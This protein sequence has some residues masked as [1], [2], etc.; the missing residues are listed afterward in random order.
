MRASRP[1]CLAVL[2]V[3]VCLGGAARGDLVFLKDGY[4]L[5]GSVRREM[6]SEFDQISK[7]MTLIPKGFFMVDDGPRRVYFSPTQVRIVEKLPAPAEE[8]VVS[9]KGAYIMSTQPMPPLED[10]LEITPWDYKT[11]RREYMFLGTPNRNV[12]LRQGLAT[13]DP[14]FARVDAVTKYPWSS[15]YLTREWDPETVYKLLLGHPDFQDPPV[16]TLKTVLAAEAKAAADLKARVARSKTPLKLVKP[17]KVLSNEEK[18]QVALDF[19]ER[20]IV[21]QRMRLVDFFAQAGW[22]DLAD[23]ELD[24]LLKDKSSEKERVAAARE[25]VDK[26]RVRDLWEQTKKWYHG[27]Q[28][29]AVRKRIAAFPTKNVSDRIQADL[30][31]MRAR[32]ESSAAL[33][34]EAD[35]ALQ[36][37]S[38]AVSTAEGRAL[39]SAVNVIRG[40]LHPATIDRLDA[41]LGQVRDWERQ[42]ARG[43]KATQ[44]PESLLSLA[45][46]GWLLGSPSAEAMPQVAVNLWKTRQMVLEYL[47]ESDL[48]GRQRILADYERTIPSRVELEEVAQMIEH[49]PPAEPVKVPAGTTVERQAG[50]GRAPTTYAL[51][52]PPEYSPSKQYPVLIVLSKAK[53]SP[54]TMIDRW[55]AAA[56]EQGYILAAPKWD[57]G[58]AG[59]YGYSEKEHDTVL[60]TLRDLRRRFAVDSDRVFL[61][62]LGEGGKMCFDVGL[63]HPDLFAG[64]LPM[65]AGPAYYPRRYWRN[66]QYLPVYAV[67]GTRA[68]ESNTLLREQFESWTIRG[69]PALWVEYKGR[70]IEWLSG[71]VPN[72]FDWMR[73]QRRAFPMRQLGTDG[74]GTTFG[75]EF[76]TMRA[77]DNR[78]YWLSTNS[79]SPRY[80]VAPSR[81]S[82][83]AEPAAM[84]GRI[85]PQTNEVTLKTQGLGQVS[86]WFGRNPRGQ[87][88]IDFDK[89]VTVRVGFRVYVIK[90]KVVPSLAV[91]LEDL[92]ARGDRKHLY[93]A[94]IDLNLR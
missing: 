24:R 58:L 23:R 49:L 30:R 56:A 15:A 8:R 36:K 2:A 1:V 50:R 75:N 60:D 40:E 28:Y 21:T 57:T 47:Q 42:Q 61:F 81:W 37:C 85:D 53:E 48:A 70:G 31:E 29:E 6:T 72:M 22:Y 17:A 77:E 7:E 84:T 90:R 63:A 87:Y 67:N 78:F 94:S 35:H 69:Y 80:T 32:L 45:I 91:L 25:K 43:K 27:G 9:T 82:N 92:Y 46:T 93:V 14:Y 16:P 83:L 59:I 68:G 3:A 76:C 34:D 10:V 13:I 86:I 11:W 88:M 64:I 5:Q 89:P 66:A 18:L 55:A 71:E 38:K 74:V 62:G 52:L 65:G 73:N 4:V 41:F 33:I 26:L 79:I 44:T 39:A 20:Q 51:R 12:R 54:E 19:R